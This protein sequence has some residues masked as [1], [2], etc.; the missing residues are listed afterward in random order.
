MLPY[1]HVLLADACLRAGQ[2]EAARAAVDEGL[3][4]T[5]GDGGVHRGELLRI[6]ALLGAEERQQ[7]LDQAKEVAQRLSSPWLQERI[8]RSRASLRD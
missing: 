6:A 7:L 4:A 8:A 3:E 2:S 1:L 5:S